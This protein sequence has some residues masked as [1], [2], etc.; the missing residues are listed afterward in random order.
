MV[1]V[2]KES[3]IRLLNLRPHGAEGGYFSEQYLSGSWRL[4]DGRSAVDTIYYMLT[5]DSPVGHA[6]V[7]KSV[8]IH[9]Y[10]AG[11]PLRYTTIDPLGKVDSFILGPDLANGHELQHAVEG[12]DWKATQLMGGTFG[13][14]SEVVVPAF[15]PKDRII[16]RRSE[17]AEIFPDL[18]V[19]LLDLA[20]R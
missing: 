11:S 18:D 12:G 2:T 19:Q 14:I 15:S 5:D 4:P 10:H 1:A 13:L 3:L 8:T 20:W 9:F 17:L 16:A 6:H 7:N